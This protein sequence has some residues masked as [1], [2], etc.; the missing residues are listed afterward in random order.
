MHVEHVQIWCKLSSISKYWYLALLTVAR[1]PRQPTCVVKIDQNVPMFKLLIIYFQ[2]IML[3]ILF[4]ICII[5]FEK[6]N[7]PKVY[8]HRLKSMHVI[9]L[10]I[11]NHIYERCCPFTKIR[12]F[13][14]HSIL[15]IKIAYMTNTIHINNIHYCRAKQVI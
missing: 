2:I 9:I 8:Y 4:G 14:A 11:N 13:F 7:Q 6:P 5:I 1:R 3:Q 12:I 15:H 10:L